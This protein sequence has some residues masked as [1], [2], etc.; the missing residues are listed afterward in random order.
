VIFSGLWLFSG[1]MGSYFIARNKTLV[2]WEVEGIR[3]LLNFYYFFSKKA[4]EIPYRQFC[5]KM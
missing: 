1:K 3:T 4:S 5:P 2:G